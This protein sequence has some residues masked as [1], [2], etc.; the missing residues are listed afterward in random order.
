MSPRPFLVG[1]RQRMT[2]RVHVVRNPFDESTVEEVCRPG[3][4]DLEQALEVSVRGSASLRSMPAYR[5]AEVLLRV[6]RGIE[7]NKEKF[8]RT[9]ALENGKPIRHARGE[10]ERATQTVTTSAEEAKRIGGEMIPMDLAPG[11]EG[12]FAITRRF[13]VGPVACITPFNF[14]LNLVAHK[15]APAI[16]A[17]CPFVLKPAS[18]T[19][20][21]ALDLAELMLDSGAPPEAVSVL[22]LAAKDSSPLAEDPRIRAVSFTGSP[23]VGWDLR[24]RAFRKKVVLELGGNAAVIVDRGADLDL[25]LERTAFGGFT[26]AGQSCVSVQRVLVHVEAFEAFVDRF[27]SKVRGLRTG[28]PLSEDT[29]VGPVISDGDAERIEAWIRE[30]VD[31]GAEVLAGGGRRGRMVEPTVITGTRPGLEVRD[32]E[33][34]APVVVVEKFP[35][36]T[37]AIAE[38]DRSDFGL[39]AGIFTRDLGSAVAAFEGIEVGAVLV[40]DV[41]TYRVDHMPYGGVRASGI[42]REGPRYAIEDYTESRLLVVKAPEAG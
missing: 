10:V 41:P 26:H 38:A 23:E 15:I 34:F 37:D 2:D 13:P 6:A 7:S 30:A 39:Q 20:L 24:R 5:R 25:A 36:V 32:R 28:D 31:A 16:A 21:S 18:Q 14:P 1:G 11:A 8:A 40:N 29:D 3:P 17:G 35:S 42:G 33:I 27:L 4:E 22:P 9:I 12:R 19:P